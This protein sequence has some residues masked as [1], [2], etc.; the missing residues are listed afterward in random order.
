MTDYIRSLKKGN[1]NAL[2]R[3]EVREGGNS[4]SPD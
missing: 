2:I 1:P 3:E 4:P